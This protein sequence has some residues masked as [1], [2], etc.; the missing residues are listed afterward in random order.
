M[1][2]AIC[3]PVPQ[4]LGKNDTEGCLV[5]YLETR[6]LQLNPFSAQ[7]YGDPP[8]PIDDLRESIRRQGIL[9]PLVITPSLT[10]GSWEVISGHR[11]LA[12]AVELGLGDIPCEVRHFP[13]KDACH[14]AVLEYNCQ[15]RKHFSHL[16]READALEQLWKRRRRAGGWQTSTI[17]RKR[18]E[19]RPRLTPSQGVGIPT[20]EKP[21]WEP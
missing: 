4:A 13:D 9:V 2:V 11:R 14:L 20:I 1:G 5:R 18:G 8:T 10:A 3:A 17:S 7:I 16:M 21:R 6:Q 12:C 19:Q 15:R